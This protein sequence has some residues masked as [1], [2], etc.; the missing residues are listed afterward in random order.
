[1]SHRDRSKHPSRPE[2]AIHP[3]KRSAAVDKVGKRKTAGPLHLDSSLLWC[4]ETSMRRTD[5]SNSDT[6]KLLHEDQYRTK[7]TLKEALSDAERS[8]LSRT[9]AKRPKLLPVRAMGLRAGMDR[10]DI[11]GVSDDIEAESYLRA[12]ARRRR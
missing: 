6:A 7:S 8:S 12:T 5:S 1:M 3:E 9:P 2:G 10:Q 4:F 11:A